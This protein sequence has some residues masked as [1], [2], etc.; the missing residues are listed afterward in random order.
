MY[1]H[2]CLLYI[3]QP[4]GCVHTHFFPL[5]YPVHSLSLSPPCFSMFQHEFLMLEM[6]YFIRSPR[7]L[8]MYNVQ[9]AGLAG[10]VW[11]GLTAWFDFMYQMKAL[12]RTKC[13]LRYSTFRHHQ[14]NETRVK[15][16]ATLCERDRDEKRLN[17]PAGMEK[18]MGLRMQRTA[19]AVAVAHPYFSKPN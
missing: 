6:C 2:S 14:H 4:N 9:L 12:K 17:E 5:P 13:P 1:T 19:A 3:V 18:R 7:Y 16:N 11:F 8:C 15:G 10:L